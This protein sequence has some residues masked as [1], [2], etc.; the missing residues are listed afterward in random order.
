MDRLATLD[1]WSDTIQER[2]CTVSYTHLD[3]YKRQDLLSVAFTSFCHDDLEICDDVFYMIIG[4]P[5]WQNLLLSD[6]LQIDRCPLCR[7]CGE[8]KWILVSRSIYLTLVQKIFCPAGLG[9]NDAWFCDL[10]ATL[11]LDVYKRQAGSKRR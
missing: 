7:W 5:R 11:Y 6:L 3:V 9:K 2:I 8:Q 10:N 4:L 1:S